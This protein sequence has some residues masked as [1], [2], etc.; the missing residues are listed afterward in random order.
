MEDLTDSTELLRTLGHRL[1]RPLT[2]ILGLSELIPLGTEK[3]V[4][5]TVFE[6][7][8]QIR[9]SAAEILEAID[10]IVDLVRAESETYRMAP[11]HLFPISQRALNLQTTVELAKSFKRHVINLIPA[12][13]P[14]V[15]ADGPRISKTLTGLLHAMI[16]ISQHGAVKMS[17]RSEDKIVVQLWSGRGKPSEGE[18]LKLDHLFRTYPDANPVAMDLLIAAC[19]IRR[20][21]GDLWLVSEPRGFNMS[22]SLPLVGDRADWRMMTEDEPS[23]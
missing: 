18:K 11:L 19:A 6:D 3:E 1:R 2:S 17:A 14:E 4:S 16:R 12:D 13:L 9:A 15:W 7:V 8:H 10:S 20:H 22:F 21:G 5:Q 23:A